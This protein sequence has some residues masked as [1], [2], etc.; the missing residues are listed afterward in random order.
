MF[1]AGMSRWDR[2][3]WTWFKGE[4]FGTRTNYASGGFALA[5]EDVWGAAQEA[6]VQ[7]DG[8]QWHKLPIHG[9]PDSIVA[10]GSEAWTITSTGTLTHYTPSGEST[11]DLRGSIPANWVRR[12]SARPVLGRTSDGTLWYGTEYGVSKQATGTW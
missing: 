10:A 8:A 2:D 1:Q 7:W 11:T 12:V 6:V 9:E 4:D 3:R 5:G